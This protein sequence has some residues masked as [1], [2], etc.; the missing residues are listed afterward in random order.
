[1]SQFLA[2]PKAGRTFFRGDKV[3]CAHHTITPARKNQVQIMQNSNTNTTP[4]KYKYKYNHTRAPARKNKVQIVQNSNTNTT[5]YKYKYNYNHTITPVCNN[6]IQIMQ[7]SYQRNH[8]TQNSFQMQYKILK[9]IE[10]K[11]CRILAIGN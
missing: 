10:Y 4:Y 3:P 6:Q 2:I 11:S 5:P 1:M 7:N 8:I 9:T